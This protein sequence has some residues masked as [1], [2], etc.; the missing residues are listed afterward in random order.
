MDGSDQKKP[1]DIA[2]FWANIAWATLLGV[3][4]IVFVITFVIAWNT[5]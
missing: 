4:T 5:R 2:R 3:L 1:E